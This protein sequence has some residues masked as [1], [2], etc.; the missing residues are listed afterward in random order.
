MPRGKQ[1]PK[2]LQQWLR[3]AEA[4]DSSREIAARLVGNQDPQSPPGPPTA[5]QAEACP[6][7]RFDSVVALTAKKTFHTPAG[8][9]DPAGGLDPRLLQGA[10][11][12]QLHPL[13]S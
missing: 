1:R 4:R 9:L 11:G 12:E 13:S 3:A 6:S 2:A 8:Q 10:D 7:S 5:A